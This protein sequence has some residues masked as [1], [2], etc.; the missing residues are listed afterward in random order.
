MSG[1]KK[2]GQT[3][4]EGANF[5]VLEPE[6]GVPELFVDGNVGTALSAGVVKV[7]F[8]VITGSVEEDGTQIEQR[9]LK[10]RLVMST[11]AWIEFCA[12]SMAIMRSQKD[13]LLQLIDEGR[14]KIAHALGET[15]E[16]PDGDG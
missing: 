1:R 7:D 14:A 4:Q 2:V 5:D 11:V 12:N 8:F 6:E 3:R 13:E 10:H 9:L 15:Q 16:K